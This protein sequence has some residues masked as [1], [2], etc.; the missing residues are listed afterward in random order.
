M[1]TTR[2]TCRPATRPTIR[3]K[4]GS[5]GQ[6][7]CIL[8]GPPIGHKLDTGWQGRLGDNSVN[9]RYSE[10]NAETAPYKL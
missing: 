4:R 1:A 10:S 3:A 2:L 7:G 8:G 5:E 9:Q 6:A